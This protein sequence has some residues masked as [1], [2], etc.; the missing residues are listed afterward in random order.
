NQFSSSRVILTDLDSSGT[1]DLVYLGENGVDLYRNQSGNSFS[2]KLHVPI[3]FA[4]NGSAL[5]IVDLL[6][7]RTQCLVSS[8]RLPGDSSQPL[9]YVDIFRNKKPH[10][11]TGVKNNVG[12]ETRLHYAQSTKFYFQDRQNSRRWLIP[13]PF[14]VY[15]VE[16]RETID[17]VSGN[18]FCDSYRYSHGFYDGVEREFRGFARVER[19]DISD[20]SKL[21]GVSQTNSN[22]AWKV[23]PA[24]T[25]TWFHTDTFIENP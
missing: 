25:V 13:L 21:K 8:S 2:P 7:N 1:A 11:L 12:A 17:R 14:P 23:P 24:R 9:V 4:V 10:P 16:R 15:C 18:V 20:F 22:P 3:P 19:T 5:D 6:G